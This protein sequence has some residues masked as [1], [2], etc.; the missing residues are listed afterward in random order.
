MRDPSLL[1]LVDY[2]ELLADISPDKLGVRDRGS[3]PRGLELETPKLTTAGSQLGLG[4]V[5]PSGCERAPCGGRGSEE[6]P[7]LRGLSSFRC[8]CGYG[9]TTTTWTGVWLPS[10]GAWLM[11]P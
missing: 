1:F 4:R 3:L 6:R 9:L 10:H 8:G 5:G 2:L 11:P 7:R